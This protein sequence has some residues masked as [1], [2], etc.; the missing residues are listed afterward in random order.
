MDKTEFLHNLDQLIDSLLNIIKSQEL[1]QSADADC[2][3]P[4]IIIED[5]DLNSNVNETIVRTVWKGAKYSRFRDISIQDDLKLFHI[6][7]DKKMI[8]FFSH[9]DDG[10]SQIPNATFELRG[11]N[12][13]SI[14]NQPTS[15]S[16]LSNDMLNC[17]ILVKLGTNNGNLL[18]INNSHLS[19]CAYY[20][21][22]I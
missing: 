3:R 9:N 1:L 12:H 14:G 6:S 13:Y 5:P 18:E 21:F 22:L 19:G 7:K 17:K 8:L 4:M 16:Q 20:F 11:S 15:D 2:I 10:E